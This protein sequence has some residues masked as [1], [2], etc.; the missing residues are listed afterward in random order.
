MTLPRLLGALAAVA[1]VGVATL[2]SAF[3]ADGSF[4]P[5]CLG[6]AKLGEN[7]ADGEVLYKFACDREI[8][9]YS[10]AT[11]N[12]QVDSFDTE[13]VV[14]TP[15]GEAVPGEDFGCSGEIPG[16]GIGCGGKAGAWN[17]VNGGVN[18]TSDPC[19]APR[20][21]LAVIIA[22]AKGRVAGPY[23]ITSSR[24]GGRLSGCPAKPSVRKHRARK[25]GRR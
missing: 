25:I 10:I 6:S 17:Q 8:R 24:T 19:G 7:R 1:A 5:N 18:L 23:R 4:Q 16:V 9:G 21:R 20:P 2:P 12:K 15:G 3:A 14:L 13:P 11:L 22:D